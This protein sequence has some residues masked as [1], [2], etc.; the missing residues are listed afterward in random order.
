MNVKSNDCVFA[1]VIFLREKKNLK[2]KFKSMNSSFLTTMKTSM[3]NMFSIVEELC[4]HQNKNFRKNIV[5]F[6]LLIEKRKIRKIKI[7]WKIMV[8]AKPS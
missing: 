2:I 6:R 1:V 8:H 4:L 7:K 3:L 5:L